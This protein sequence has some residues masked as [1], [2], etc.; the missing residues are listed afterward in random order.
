MIEG[1]IFDPKDAFEGPPSLYQHLL[2][3]KAGSA[4]R[5]DHPEPTLD[6]VVVSD[7]AVVAWISKWRVSESAKVQF[8]RAFPEKAAFFGVT[9]ESAPS[10]AAMG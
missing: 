10:Q 8:A 1:N 2:R 9:L 6:K 7:E 5:Y 4:G 3:E